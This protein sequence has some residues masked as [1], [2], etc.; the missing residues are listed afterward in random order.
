MCSVAFCIDCH[1][2]DGH[3]YMVKYLVNYVS[4]NYAT[5]IFMLSMISSDHLCEI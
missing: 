2:I 3:H 5:E 4:I 1:G